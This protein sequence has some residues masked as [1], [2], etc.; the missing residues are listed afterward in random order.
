LSAYGLRRAPLW[1]AGAFAGCAAATPPG[2]ARG[3]HWSIPL[4]GPLENGTLLVP[5]SV[6]GTGPYLFCLDPDAPVSAI[7][8]QLLDELKL[9]LTGGPP[10]RDETHAELQRGYAIVPEL[11]LG[12]LAIRG[13]TMLPVGEGFFNLDGRRVHGMLGMLGKD[14][15]AD[16]LVFGFDRDQ[17]VVTLSVP[18]VFTP[19]PGAT[20]IAYTRTDV[21]PGVDG[22]APTTSTGAS[23]DARSVPRRVAAAQVGGL[24]LQ[25]HLDLGAPVSQL[26]PE[27]MAKAGLTPAAVAEPIRLVDEGLTARTVDRAAHADVTLS[28]AAPADYRGTT[29]TVIDAS[30]FTRPC[31]GNAG[32]IYPAPAH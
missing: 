8:G 18:A 4:V 27:A 16:R 11:K 9:D 17:G 28:H 20:S 31:E 22:R 6:A 23:V 24:P 29:L 26:R 2:F 32:C 25:I 21:D 19:P 3:D 5:V 15:L 1:L 7:D 12:D 30:P 10:L 13:R 14:V